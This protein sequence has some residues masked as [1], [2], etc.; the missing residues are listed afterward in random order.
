MSAIVKARN[1]QNG[2][3][4]FESRADPLHLL[5][6]DDVEKWQAFCVIAL[7]QAGLGDA[8][9][10]EVKACKQDALKAARIGREAGEVIA[11][12]VRDPEAAKY[13]VQLLDEFGVMS[14]AEYAAL[15]PD[16]FV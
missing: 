3:A 5:P 10:Q 13:I 7:H 12:I 14:Y 6:R 16:P 8:F 9:Y 11:R 2:L 4:R 15:L 1:G